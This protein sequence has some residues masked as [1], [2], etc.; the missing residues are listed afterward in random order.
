MEKDN[1]PIY[2]IKRYIIEVLEA[3]I[4]LAILFYFKNGKIQINLKMALIIGLV[5]LILEEYNPKF[6]SNIKGG[7]FTFTTNM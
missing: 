3:T 6:S 2:Y 7:I 4:A 1:K 5:T